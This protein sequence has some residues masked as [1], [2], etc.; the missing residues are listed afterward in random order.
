MGND[1]DVPSNV[2]G[3]IDLNERQAWIVAQT[4][5]GAGVERRTVQEKFDVSAKTAKRDLSQLV[6]R[7][8]VEYVR[9]PH[10]GFYKRKQ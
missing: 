3:D 5:K 1:P 7:G 10:P 8:L 6:K 2:P 9:R 4:G